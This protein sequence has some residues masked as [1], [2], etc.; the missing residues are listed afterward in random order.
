M[1]RQEHGQTM[2][3]LSGVRSNYMLSVPRQTSISLCLVCNGTTV[4]CQRRWPLTWLLLGTVGGTPHVQTEQAKEC[5][6]T[7][8]IEETLPTAY[9]RIKM[10][11]GHMA[12][13]L[14]GFLL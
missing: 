1:I 2:V 7:Q 3:H 12:R 6:S 5:G 13:S 9:R 4:S 11:P 14:V 8:R 10:R